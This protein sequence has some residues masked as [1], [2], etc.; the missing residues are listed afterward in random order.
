MVAGKVLLVDDDRW[1]AELLAGELQGAGYQVQIAEHTLD[2]ITAIDEF[3]PDVITLDVFMPGP[4]G[5]VLLH[6]LQ[7]YTDLAQIPVVL[8]TSSASDIPTDSTRAYGV[9][10]VLDK[11]TMQPG[12]IVAAVKRCMA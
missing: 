9:T 12:D 2:A 8:C 6:E 5:I 10:S 4:N 7:S 3:T 1:L 11:T